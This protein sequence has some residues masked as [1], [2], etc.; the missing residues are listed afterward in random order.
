[1]RDVNYKQ[2]LPERHIAGNI[3]HLNHF[4]T[5]IFSEQ[6]LCWSYNMLIHI[7]PKLLLVRH[8]LHCAQVMFGFVV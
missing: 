5:Y 1:M 8:F 7:S 2:P 6:V 4:D 3:L